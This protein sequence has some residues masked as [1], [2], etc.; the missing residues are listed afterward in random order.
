MPDKSHTSSTLTLNRLS[1]YLRC[2]RHLQAEGTSTVSS[3]E[4]AQRFHLSSSQIRKDLAH[5]G[6]FGVRGVGYQVDELADHLHSLLGL[7]VQHRLILVGVGNLGSALTGYFGFNDDSFRVVAGVDDSA[8]R[9]GTRVGKITVEPANKLA[10]VVARSGADVGV[11]TVPAEAAESAL[12]ALLAAGLR[13]IINFAPILLRAPEGVLLKNV[14]MRIHLE[15][16]AYYL[17]V[18]EISEETLERAARARD[19]KS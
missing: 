6:E 12:E 15:E 2:L 8:E 9:I 14:D 5:F 4:L 13:S 18:P 17:K 16:V 3:Q 7:D 11:I 10:E 19:L 1:V